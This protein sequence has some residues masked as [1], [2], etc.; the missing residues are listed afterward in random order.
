MSER[1]VVYEVIVAGHQVYRV[2]AK[3]D[4]PTGAALCAECRHA[5]TRQLLVEGDAQVGHFWWCACG[6]RRWHGLAEP[7]QETTVPADDYE[8]WLADSRAPRGD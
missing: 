1:N 5:E 3:R 7:G 8:R 2:F 6:Q 4:D